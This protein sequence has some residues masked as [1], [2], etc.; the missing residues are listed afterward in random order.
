M[1]VP[2]SATAATGYSNYGIAF[3]STECSGTGA[4]YNKVRTA[5]W[6]YNGNDAQPPNTVP[7]YRCK[8]TATGYAASTHFA[9]TGSSCEGLGTVEFLLGYG[10]AN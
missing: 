2:I 6:L 10:L 5:G 3:N 9:S 8:S 4:G 1:L 7:V